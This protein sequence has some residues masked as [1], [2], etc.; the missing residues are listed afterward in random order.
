[1]F[2]EQVSAQPGNGAASAFTYEFGAGV[3]EMAVVAC[4]VPFT[5]VLPQVWKKVLSVPQDE[6]AA[7]FRASQLMPDWRI[8][9]H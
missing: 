5:C 8:I 6:D 2:I 7:R 3:I 1:V 9:G 4:G